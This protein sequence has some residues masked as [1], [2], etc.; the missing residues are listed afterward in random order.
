MSNPFDAPAA[1]PAAPTGTGHLDAV[2]AMKDGW[3]LLMEHFVVL[4][5]AV[6][7]SFILY[8]ISAMLCL[9]PIFLVAPVVYW[10]HIKLSLDALDGPPQFETLLEGFNKIGDVWLPMIALFVLQFIAA[11]PGAIL[12]QMIQF[13]AGILAEDSVLLV[14][15]ASLFGTVISL[16]WSIGIL[17]RFLPAPFLVVDRGMGP[18]DAMAEAW[19]MTDGANWGQ[20]ALLYAFVAMTGVIGLFICFVGV[21]P[22]QAL[23]MVAMASATRQ[24]LGER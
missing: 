8:T 19:N 14:L 10:G 6:I 11:L 7:V 9:I 13:T 18:A 2:Q 23:T 15:A 5:G 1:P 20:A 16:G 22:A 21:I 24:L 12:S 4:A 17:S 3:N